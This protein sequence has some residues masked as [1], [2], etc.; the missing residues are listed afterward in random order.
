MYE[1][2]LDVSGVKILDELKMDVGSIKWVYHQ[3]LPNMEL[4]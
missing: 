4:H 1:H 3:N 2:N